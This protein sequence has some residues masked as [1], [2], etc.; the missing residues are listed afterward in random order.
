MKIQFF[1]DDRNPKANSVA[2]FCRVRGKVQGVGFR[3]SAIREAQRLGIKGFVRN[4]SDGN[5]E[6]WAEGSRKQLDLLLKWLHRGPP[7]AR[8]D[9]VKTE[10]KEPRGYDDFSVEY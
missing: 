10:E 8:V 3:Y 7:Y 6:V 2:F 4:S 1:N 9:S 5:V